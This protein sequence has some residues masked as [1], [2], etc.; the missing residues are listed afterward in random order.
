MFENKAQWAYET[1]ACQIVAEYQMP[2]VKNAF[3]EGTFCM[4]RYNEAMDA[5]DRLRS[6]LGVQDEDK[7]VECMI[8]AFEE[9]QR[10]L[11]LRMYHYGATHGE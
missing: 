11:C 2:G 3:R 5:Y 7:D 10:E 1:M 4:Q 6:R 9:I 8:C